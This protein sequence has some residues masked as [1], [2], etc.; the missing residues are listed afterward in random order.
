[1]IKILLVICILLTSCK[2]EETI[3]LQDIEY[4]KDQST[5]LLN[6]KNININQMYDLYVFSG[7]ATLNTIIDKHIIDI[8]NSGD[9]RL[10]FKDIYMMPYVN[11]DINFRSN[12]DNITVNIYDEYKTYYY[13]DMYDISIF[14]KYDTYVDVALTLHEEDIYEISNFMVVNDQIVDYVAIN[15]VG[16]QPEFSKV[17]HFAKDAG[18]YFYLIDQDDNIVY[19]GSIGNVIY[20]EASQEYFLEGYFN[21]YTIEGSYKIVSQ[22]GHISYPFVIKNNIYDDLII[23]MVKMIASQ[24]CGYDLSYDIYGDLSHKACHLQESLSPNY[25]GF[26]SIKGGWHDAGDYGRYTNTI[27]KTLID[28][29][30]SY[31]INPNLFSDNMNLEY[32]NN[33]TSDILDE[34]KIGLEYLMNVQDDYGGIFHKVS[35]ES[36][37]LITMPENDLS[38]L[39]SLNSDTA[40]TAAAAGIL[41]LASYIFK[42][43]DSEYADVL[44]QKADRAYEFVEKHGFVKGITPD[45]FITGNYNDDED[46]SERYFMY[47]SYYYTTKQQE[48]YNKIIDNNLINQVSL[49]EGNYKSF[50]MYATA[51]MILNNQYN[52]IKQHNIIINNLLKHSYYQHDKI[53]NSQFKITL[54]QYLW[55][56]NTTNAE[57]LL[58]LAFAYYVNNDINLKSSIISTMDYYLGNNSIEQSFITGYG[59]KYPKNIHHRVTMSNNT[60]IKGA[61]VGGPN[62]SREDDIVTDTYNDNTPMAKS[63]LDDNRSYSSNEVMIN[64]NSIVILLLSI[65]LL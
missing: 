39:Y 29:I 7:E 12:N 6:N 22:Y 38:D 11:Y 13:G 24:K 15:Q 54:D 55:N 21:D 56:S 57:A 63:Y 64:S 47:M 40:S 62:A 17:A 19:K 53:N 46:L 58:S 9:I 48:Y 34:I 16:Y 60:T 42:D 52:D 44:K 49:F 65:M 26:K 14:S 27:N 59:S 25:V 61:L 5:T 20:D 23:D 33:G 10:I 28:L 1:M 8:T 32:S 51:L 50:G 41:N 30:L 36:F 43:I 4:I 18:S 35:T 3:I 31:M 2:T 37:A 45:Y